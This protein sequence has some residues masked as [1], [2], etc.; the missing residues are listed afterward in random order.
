MAGTKIQGQNTAQTCH[1]SGYKLKGAFLI[2]TSPFGLAICSILCK[3]QLHHII[4]SYRAN[5]LDQLLVCGPL[6]PAKWKRKTCQELHGSPDPERPKPSP[7]RRILVR[8]MTSHRKPQSP[9]IF[10]LVQAFLMVL[11]HTE[12]QNHPPPPQ[13]PPL[14]TRKIKTY[15]SFD[16]HLGWLV[17]SSNT[18]Y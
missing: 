18:D 11:T 1:P 14:E 6:G 2:Q 16:C 8:A 3:L 17:I 15:F 13:S 12:F 10:Q 9:S 5:N 7:T 4:D